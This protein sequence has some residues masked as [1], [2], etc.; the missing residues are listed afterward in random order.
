M[1]EFHNH[2]HDSCNE[3]HEHLHSA[4]DESPAVFSA[5]LPIT[6]DNEI[7]AKELISG[8]IKYFKTIKQWSNDNHCHIGHIKSFVEDG[9]NL[10][11]WIATTGKDININGFDNDDKDIKVKTTTLHIT[12]IIFGAEEDRLREIMLDNLKKISN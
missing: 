9:K 10:K 5:S 6:F 8:L 12:A 7:P 3:H 1:N 11:I 2:N 4:P